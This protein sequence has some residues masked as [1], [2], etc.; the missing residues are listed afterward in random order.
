MDHLL[1]YVLNIEMSLSILW[2]HFSCDGAIHG[3]HGEHINFV[4]CEYNR[5]FIVYTT[6]VKFVCYIDKLL[7]FL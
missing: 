4:V 2:I 7:A 3:H 5:R 6:L 1:V